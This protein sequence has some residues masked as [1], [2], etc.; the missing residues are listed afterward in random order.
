M[1]AGF[2]GFQGIPVFTTH[3]PEQVLKNPAEFKRPIWDDLKR[4]MAELGRPV[5]S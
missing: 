5:R 3:H 1:S 2:R 4:M